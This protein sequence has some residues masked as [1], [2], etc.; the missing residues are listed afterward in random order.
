MC[1]FGV[2][3]IVCVVCVWGMGGEYVCVMC[4]VC[5]WRGWTWCVRMQYVCDV[6]V[7]VCFCGVGGSLRRLHGRVRAC[8]IGRISQ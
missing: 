4:G 5:V 7:F 1:V 3:Y 2:Y 6:C 8:K